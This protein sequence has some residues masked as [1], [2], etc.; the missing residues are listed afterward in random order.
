MSRSTWTIRRRTVRTDFRHRRCTWNP[1]PPLRRPE[2]ETWAQCL[3]FMYF[4]CACL[5]VD[6]DLCSFC[7]HSFSFFMILSAALWRRASPSTRP[8]QTPT[9]APPPTRITESWRRPETA[10][11]PPLPATGTIAPPHQTDTVTTTAMYSS[12]H[13][14]AAITDQGAANVGRKRITAA[15]YNGYI[16]TN[17]QRHNSAATAKTDMVAS[18][19]KN[20]SPHLMNAKAGWCWRHRSPHRPGRARRAPHHRRWHC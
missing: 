7:L 12:P 13:R 6:V 8:Q 10:P 15:V 17:G 19:T 18:A 14:T 16:P 1:K 4:F 5:H 20:R 3:V 9:N 2:K 11:R